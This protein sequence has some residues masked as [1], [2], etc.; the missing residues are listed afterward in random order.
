MPQLAGSVPLSVCVLY[1]DAA[2]AVVEHD[3]ETGDV[4]ARGAFDLDGFARIRADIVVVDFV[5]AEIVE[6]GGAR[7]STCIAAR[8]DDAI[9]RG[10]DDDGVA[11]GKRRHH[12]GWR[13]PSRRRD[14]CSSR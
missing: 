12:A 2:V 7:R 11:G 4:G 3:A 1:S 9:G 14:R 10:R 6:V 5:E 13:S 8:A